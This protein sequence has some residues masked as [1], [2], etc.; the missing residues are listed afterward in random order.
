MKTYL[1]PLVALMGTSS[2]LASSAGTETSIAGQNLALTSAQANRLEVLKKH[3]AGQGSEK[4]LSGING[5][6]S[7]S[8]SNDLNPL[9]DAATGTNSEGNIVCV[10][11]QKIIAS[12]KPSDLGRDLSKEASTKSIESALQKSADGKEVV[13]HK[14]T[15]EDPSEAD[16]EIE[17]DAVTTVWSAKALGLDSKADYCLITSTK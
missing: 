8:D 10:K 11:D 15:V 14:V 7:N 5:P 3:I 12:P 4:A 16:K 1:F 9:H 17:A 2:L 13:A 6:S